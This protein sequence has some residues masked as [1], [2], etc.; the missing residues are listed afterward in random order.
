MRPTAFPSHTGLYVP[1]KGTRD[2]K[3]GGEEWGISEICRCS[4][5]CGAIAPRVMGREGLTAGFIGGQSCVARGER[6]LSGRMQSACKGTHTLW[7]V[8][9]SPPRGWEGGRGTTR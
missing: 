4:P 8:K 7:P 3:G 9:H 6:L 5:R 2:E 1:A